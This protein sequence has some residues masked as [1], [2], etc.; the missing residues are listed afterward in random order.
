M[1]A[2][3]AGGRRARLVEKRHVVRETWH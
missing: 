2:R 1:S 3:R